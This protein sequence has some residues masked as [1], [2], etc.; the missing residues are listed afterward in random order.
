MPLLNSAKIYAADVGPLLRPGERLLAMG[1]YHEP[2]NGDESRL[3]AEPPADDR[4]LQ[5]FDLLAGGLQIN[6]DRV[7]RALSGLVGAGTPESAAGRLWRAGQQ[8]RH[9]D[10]A[11]TSERF[12]L[13][14]R[15][16][17]TRGAF[18]VAFSAERSDITRVRQTA[19]L[20]FQWAR[21]ELTFA[22]GSTLAFNAALL[23]WVA[24]AR[25]RKALTTP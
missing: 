21:I 17:L 9:A 10:W 20:P 13:L 1:A 23:D 7:R 19:W 24:A 16:E 11:A 8:A 5:G 3:R 25:L 6:P 4:V 12:L 14:E 2:L 18:T 15:A 22:D